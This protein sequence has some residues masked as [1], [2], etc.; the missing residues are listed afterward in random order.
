[1]PISMNHSQVGSS[2][3]FPATVFIP[4]QYARAPAPA[5]VDVFDHVQPLAGIT[6]G[7]WIAMAH[8]RYSGGLIMAQPPQMAIRFNTADKVPCHRNLSWYGRDPW[9]AVLVRQYQGKKL[10]RIRDG[11]PLRDP[12]TLGTFK[13]VSA[14]PPAMAMA[15]PPAPAP[16][17]ESPR[18]STARPSSS[19]KRAISSST[20]ASPIPW[21]YRP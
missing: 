17:P 14:P 15:I 20:T 5:Q 2:L 21:A 7:T 12:I 11:E 6:T 4:A 9:D 3:S 10:V 8:G 1:M 19:A 13:P 18:A 16:G